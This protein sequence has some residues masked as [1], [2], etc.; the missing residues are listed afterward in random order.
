MTTLAGLL[1]DVD[2]EF[3]DV[4]SLVAPLGP[5][6]DRWD[7]ATPAELVAARFEAVDASWRRALCSSCS[8]SLIATPPQPM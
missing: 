4:R 2:A 8:R 5:R 1:T 7:L 3:D 6:D